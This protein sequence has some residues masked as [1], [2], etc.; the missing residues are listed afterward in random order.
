MDPAPQSAVEP[1]PEVQPQLVQE[2]RPAL[3]TDR[4]RSPIARSPHWGMGRKFVSLSPSAKAHPFTV[5]PPPFRKRSGSASLLVPPPAPIRGYR[6]FL[7]LRL[8]DEP[9]T[10]RA[11]QPRD[12]TRLDRRIPSRRSAEAARTHV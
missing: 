10:G 5:T 3:G 2:S 4:R 12:T 7:S 1:A 9:R 11:L 6:R 8:C